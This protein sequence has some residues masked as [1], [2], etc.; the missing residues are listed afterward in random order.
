MDN[1][2]VQ[3]ENPRHI[4]LSAMVEAVLRRVFSAYSRLIVAAE[5]GSGFSGSRVFL[6][7]PISTGQAPELPVVVKVAP[8]HLVEQEY[9]AYQT[10]IR[11]KLSGAA[12]IRTG[13]IRLSDSSLAGL[14][15]QLVGSGIFEVQSLFQ[16]C[17]Q[18]GVRDVWE[19]LERRLFKRL[20]PLWQFNYALSQ[21]TYRAGS[22]RLLPVNWIIA[23]LPPASG[24]AL[25]GKRIH[26]L[27]P[28]N[29]A[30]VSLQRGDAVQL[31][32]FVVT[33]VDPVGAT[34]TLDLPVSPDTTPAPS[35][36]VRLHPVER[37]D[38]FRANEVPPSLRGVV[39]ATRADLLRSAVRRV[40]EKG[41]MSAEWNSARLL[42]P[43]AR[44]VT[45]P[46]PL[47]VWPDVLCE[48]G[49]VRIA[50]V[51]GDLNMENVLVTLDTGD[52][53]LI[54]FTMTRQDHVLHDLLRLET[55]VVTWLLPN[56]LAEAGLPPWTIHRW[57][58]QL[59]D[60]DYAG[61]G[62]LSPGLRK[63]FIILSSIRQAAQSLLANP[64]DWGEYY[65]GLALYLVGS[66]KFVNLGESPVAP[67]PRQVA[68][69]GAASAL[70][71]VNAPKPT[72]VHW[73]PSSTR[74]KA[75]SAVV[76][77]A[78][79][80]SLDYGDYNGAGAQQ[81]SWPPFVAGPPVLHPRQFFG[82]RRELKRLFS[83]WKR[84]PLQN[85]AII[86]PRRSGKTSLL[87]YLQRIT[88]TP[89]D[90]LRPGQRADWLPDPV[91]YRWAFVDFQDV[92]M[93]NRE[94]LLGHLLA[95]MGLAMFSGGCAL[96]DFM[97]IV[98]RELH[99]PTIVLLDE[100]GVALERYPELDIAFW[101]SLRSL[102]TNYTGGRLA[103]V[104]ASHE[105]PERLAHQSGVGSPFFNIF[106]YTTTLGPLTEPEARE[107]IASAP[108]PFPAPDVEW[109]L[110][111]SGRWPLLLQILC[112]ERL[113]ALEEGEAG[114][115]WRSEA[116]H[117]M[118]PFR[119]LL[120]F[121]GE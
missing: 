37:S 93:R 5:L 107:L 32:G 39:T 86:G 13:P 17:R 34:V 20:M 44:D 85:A 90:E 95:A 27:S 73:P 102:A 26:A 101:E 117:Q 115:D 113:L 10:Y 57:Y 22:D 82:R 2:P 112:R 8:V 28:T 119:S 29:W 14:C 16:F 40:W 76:H 36:R 100:I 92:R 103:F 72:A 45:L 87:F 64:D 97:D 99:T 121:G 104:L 43:D 3:I 59:H 94:T 108:L 54:D 88:T 89:A 4:P 47:S 109:I 38:V 55:G 116:L 21:F 110:V 62:Q 68:L 49:R 98:S 75:A 81:A 111:Q 24:D 30:D 25:G 33:E 71:L 35:C 77:D 31:E 60:L 69:W 1:R 7:H 15:Y 106:G 6:V 51:H 11:N 91:C 48:T 63:T 50:T 70:H 84:P 9:H 53:R 105:S 80:Y 78:S 114:D 118:A 23:T 46:N 19:V 79:D 52:V 58:T 120:Q 42:W 65:R 83:L 96:D 74:Q 41:G 61:L 66:L 12:E 67:L 56:F 18:A